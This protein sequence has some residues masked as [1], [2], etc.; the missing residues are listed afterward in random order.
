[1]D[2]VVNYLKRFK[3]NGL[4]LNAGASLNIVESLQGVLNT[5]VDGPGIV[6][7]LVSALGI[8][9]AGENMGPSMLFLDEVNKASAIE[10]DGRSNSSFVQNIFLTI[11]RERNVIVVI[12]TSETGVANYLLSLNGGRIRP[13]PGFAT[14][15]WDPNSGNAPE[16]TDIDWTVQ[17][18]QGLL[19]FEFPN[20]INMIDTSFLEDGMTPGDAVSHVKLELATRLVAVP[21]TLV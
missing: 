5:S 20:V 16:W 21:T 9:Q 6:S 1:M 19:E 3:R 18:L 8:S 7:A 13:F 10:Q 12:L 17:Q 14:E 11:G 2:V 15:G 4:Y